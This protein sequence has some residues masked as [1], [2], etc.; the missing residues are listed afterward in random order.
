MEKI[1]VLI[2]LKEKPT[3]GTHFLAFSDRSETPNHKKS[4]KGEQKMMCLQ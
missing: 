4:M 2:I 3:F 1:K